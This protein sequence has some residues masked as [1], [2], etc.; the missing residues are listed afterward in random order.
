MR[1]P[2]P[3]TPNASS[4]RRVFVCPHY[5]ADTAPMKWRVPSDAEFVW[6]T[7]EGL[8]VVYFANSG[9]THCLND[10]GAEALRY[11]QRQSASA[12]ELCEHVARTLEKPPPDTF[13]SDMQQ[14]LEQFDELGLIEP[15]P[16]ESR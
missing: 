10:I 9:D 1:Q 4:D 6:R 12:D 2:I 3:N 14:L 5:P 16:D 15:V 8:H 11:L 13:F 7:W